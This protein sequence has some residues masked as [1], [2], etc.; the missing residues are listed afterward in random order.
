M[1]MVKTKLIV[2]LLCIGAFSSYAQSYEWSSAKVDGSR[3]G[4]VAPDHGNLHATLGQFFENGDFRSPN[5]KTFKAGTSTA[6]V[7]AAV[8]AAQPK[9]QRVKTVIAYSE[10]EMSANKIYE[11]ALSN[12]F[13]EI[14]MDKVSQLSGKKVDVGICNYGGIRADM[15]KGNVILDDIL[16][17]FPF[18][19]NI[20]Y[21]E[22]KGSELRK[23]FETM[24][25]TYFQAIGGVEIVAEGGKLTKVLIGGEPLDDERTYTVATIS[26]L[27]YGGDS[28]TLAQNAMN[29]EVYDVQI[30]TAV[31]DY[32]E[33]LK[34]QGKNI[35]APKVT[36]V[37][38]K[39]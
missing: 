17:M 4:C 36:H 20:V 19:N 12:W 16:S 37:T 27:L 29:L 11:S 23:I 28:L 10:D 21:L 34:A 33:N 32:I 30:V 18:K 35:T 13:V 14:V 7:A 8:A 3:T 1:E 2:F 5:G 25:A 6:K 22:H 15:P 9:M 31:L 26:F 38:V 39:K 24:A